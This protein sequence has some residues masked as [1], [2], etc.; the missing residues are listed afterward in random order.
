M[1]RSS[2]GGGGEA[3]LAWGSG[4]NGET[5]AGLS[6]QKDLLPWAVVPVWFGGGVIGALVSR[7]I[8]S[9]DPPW[10]PQLHDFVNLGKSGLWFSAVVPALCVW[11]QPEVG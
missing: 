1:V 4:P 5:G 8:T 6:F 2:P 9:S 10:G 11:V 7:A 3:S